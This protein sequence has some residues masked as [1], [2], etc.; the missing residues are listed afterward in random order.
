MELVVVIVVL[1]MVVVAV[2][3]VVEVAVV[4]VLVILVVVVR[5]MVGVVAGAV[6]VVVEVFRSIPSHFMLFTPAS[7]PSCMCVFFYCLSVKKSVSSHMN[8]NTHAPTPISVNYSFS[9]KIDLPGEH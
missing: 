9:K 4:V 8:S 5:V 2:E 7:C 6:M 3:V 1:V